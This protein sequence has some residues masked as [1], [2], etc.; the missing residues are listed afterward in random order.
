MKSPL[1]RGCV[2][3]FLQDAGIS[4]PVLTEN[5][6]TRTF[7]R[8]VV[9]SRARNNQNRTLRPDVEITEAPMS[10]NAMETTKPTPNLGG[11]VNAFCSST[12]IIGKDLTPAS[13]PPART[14]IFPATK[15]ATDSSDSVCDKRQLTSEKEPIMPPPKR[16]AGDRADFTNSADTPTTG[17][18]VDKRSEGSSSMVANKQ[19]KVVAA[20]INAEAPVQAEGV[21]TT[22]EADKFSVVCLRF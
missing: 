14:G 13:V 2:S 22:G 6:D 18:D 8:E 11:D 17:T 4:H 20:R 3:R 21:T 1:F 5:T 19:S 16:G 15:V 9:A 7:F 10:E 12:D